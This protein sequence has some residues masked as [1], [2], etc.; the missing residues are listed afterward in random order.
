MVHMT[1]INDLD[2]SPLQ[3]L[4][5]VVKFGKFNCELDASFCM[6]LG[7]RAYPTIW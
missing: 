3:A 6:M 7:I 1:T 5:G 2:A 4:R